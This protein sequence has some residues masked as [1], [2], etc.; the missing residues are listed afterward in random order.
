MKNDALPTSGTDVIY[1]CLAQLSASE[2][3]LA[4]PQHQ[5]ASMQ[6]VFCRRLPLCRF[7]ALV[8][9]VGTA[10]LNGAASSALGIGQSASHEKVNNGARFAGGNLSLIHI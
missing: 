3:L 1:C 6:E 7:D 9:H 4:S 8:I 10:F 2:V 5:P